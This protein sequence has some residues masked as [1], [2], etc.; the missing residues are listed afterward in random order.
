MN[1]AVSPVGGDPRWSVGVATVIVVALSAAADVA[2][3]FTLRRSRVAAWAL[4]AL[5]VL[6]AVGGVAF[7]SFLAPLAVTGAR[8]AVLVLL[9]QPV[10]RR[11]VRR[12]PR[13]LQ[14]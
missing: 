12:P 2:A 5:S 10:A 14:R 9:L 8:I 1:R 6:A 13:A 4:M 7:G 11:W 3:F